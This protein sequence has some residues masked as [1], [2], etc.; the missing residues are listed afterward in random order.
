MRDRQL[1]TVAVA[2]LA[3]ALAAVAPARAQGPMQIT[4]GA[5]ATKPTPPSHAT[6]PKRVKPS[7]V[8]PSATFGPA[9]AAAPTAAPQPAA[10]SPGREP[11][12]AYGA[13][14]RGYYL[15]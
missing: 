4:P 8:R 15:T 7:T 6:A 2:I 13:Y 10:T 14:Q 3:V 1:S 11:D 12:L 5:P 9:P